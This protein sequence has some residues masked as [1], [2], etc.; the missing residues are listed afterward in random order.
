MRRLEC[1]VWMFGR[2]LTNPPP[3]S[4]A[5]L[6]LLPLVV[7]WRHDVVIVMTVA[8]CLDSGS[9]GKFDIALFDCG[10]AFCGQDDCGVF[11]AD[12]CDRPL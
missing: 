9:V 1:R 4:C 2:R 6:L 11:V 5:G 8:C 12:I 3:V 7:R 10:D